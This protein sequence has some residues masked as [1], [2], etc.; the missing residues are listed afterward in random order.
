[1]IPILLFKYESFML[2]VYLLLCCFFNETQHE[3]WQR[4]KITW[5]DFL[6]WQ[7]I[8][9]VCIPVLKNIYFELNDRNDFRMMFYSCQADSQTFFKEVV[10]KMRNSFF[11]IFIIA[12][13]KFELV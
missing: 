2:L 13:S 1:M 4:M 10:S 5:A 6:L 11:A 8:K 3:R 12:F 9:I 7:V